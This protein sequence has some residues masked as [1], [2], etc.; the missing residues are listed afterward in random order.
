[1][2]SSALALHPHYLSLLARINIQHLT[3]DITT[4]ALTREK[5]NALRH[6]LR[7][8]R[9]FQ[10]NPVMPLADRYLVSAENIRRLSIQ[11]KLI[12]ILSTF[13]FEL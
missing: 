12:W 5:Q 13:L 8:D 7:R 10:R 1:V 11:P 3:S 9:P 2:P 4:P 6:A